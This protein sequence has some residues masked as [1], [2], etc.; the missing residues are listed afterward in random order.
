MKA[1]SSPWPSASEP[2]LTISF[3]PSPSMSPIATCPPGVVRCAGSV[4]SNTLDPSAPL[5]ARSTPS[6]V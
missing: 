3:H 6:E 4:T 2:Q 1:I 5:T